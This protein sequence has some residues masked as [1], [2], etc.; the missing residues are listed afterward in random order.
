MPR[1]D[2]WT[3]V[4]DLSDETLMESVIEALATDVVATM[5]LDDRSLEPERRAEAV[6]DDERQIHSHQFR[7][8]EGFGPRR[9]C[10]TGRPWSKSRRRKRTLRVQTSGP[11]R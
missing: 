9:S 2:R 8:T 7:F 5:T 10:L 4:A 1:A 3:A 11:R 6:T